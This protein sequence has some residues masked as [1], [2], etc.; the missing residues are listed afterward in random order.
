MRY[1]LAG[2]LLLSG[3]TDLF[4]VIPEGFQPREAGPLDASLRDSGSALSDG[5]GIDA[6]QQPP[7]QAPP[8]SADSETDKQLLCF[9]FEGDAEDGSIPATDGVLRGELGYA[10]DRF[11]KDRGAIVF[12]D[13]EDRM[14]IPLGEDEVPTSKVSISAWIQPTELPQGDRY[15]LSA[16][17]QRNDSNQDDPFF[18]SLQGGKP[19]FAVGA[20]V[21]G[22]EATSV[23]AIEPLPVN[24]FS[25]LLALFDPARPNP[26]RLYVDGALVGISDG[27]LEGPLDSRSGQA[28]MLG[29]T[30]DGISSHSGHFNGAI[31]ELKVWSRG[32]SDAEI[33][34]EAGRWVE[35]FEF[36]IGPEWECD[37][38]RGQLSTVDDGA[39]RTETA[40]QLTDGYCERLVFPSNPSIARIHWQ[41]KWDVNSSSETA[42]KISDANNTT[43]IQ[44][45]ISSDSYRYYALADNIEQELRDQ[46]SQG[47]Q[48]ID[49][50]F[51]WERR[52]L[53]LR[54][55]DQEE[56]EAD[57]VNA[58]Q[59]AGQL[60]LWSSGR[61]PIQVDE[62]TFELD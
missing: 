29:A 33:G 49:L 19:R 48:H 42:L 25:H 5:G 60:S 35:N 6:G 31:D 22:G 55:D 14:E 59:G 37:E 61:D 8:C 41:M 52:R 57:I 1:L 21:W 18:L 16:S 20:M 38:G 28:L 45:G 53:W 50:R 4:R 23:T 62:I 58:A 34:L 44:V 12:D 54:V 7:A 27:V 15:L 43:V 26:T 39:D 13:D 3:C 40:A 24:R 11:G 46:S 51:D 47:Y 32:L 30:Q 9:L 10:P 17:T 36:G 2:L 56:Y